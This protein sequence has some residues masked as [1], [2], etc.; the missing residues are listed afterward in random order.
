M[1]H[2]ALVRLG[3]GGVE[4]A[5]AVGVSASVARSWL[6]GARVPRPGARR[7]LELL[8]PQVAAAAWDRAVSGARPAS[9][10]AKPPTKA[11]SAKGSPA[12]SVVPS[13]REIAKSVEA[14]ADPAAELAELLDD[15]RAARRS[16]PTPSELVKIA[17]AEAT[18]VE[19]LERLREGARLREVA[20]PLTH[21]EERIAC[22]LTVERIVF[23]ALDAWKPG[24]E[25]PASVCRYAVRHVGEDLRAFA[26]RL[27]DF[28]DVDGDAL[29]EL[30]EMTKCPKWA[31]SVAA[32]S[33]L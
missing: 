17:H 15:V 5:Q 33:G 11:P 23:A 32:R 19:R 25:H 9:R 20:A 30:V 6:T 10:A 14:A 12:R 1:G 28:G 7:R 13:Q 29:A 18:L 26:D 3:L 27:A 8:Y 16:H 21:S 2:A 31:A 24:D 22:L 4:L